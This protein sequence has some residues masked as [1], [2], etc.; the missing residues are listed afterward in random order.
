MK[1]NIE[2]F[3][4]R[5]LSD[6]KLVRQ[7]IRDQGEPDDSLSFPTVVAVDEAGEILGV[8]STD[9]Q[10]NL[11]VA[12]PL[13][14]NKKIRGYRVIVGLVDAYDE[15]MRGMGI[16]SYVHSVDENNKPWLNMIERAYGDEPY[17]KQNGRLFFIKKLDAPQRSVN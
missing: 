13:V 8:L 17:A 4:I 7:F 2:Y 5:E 12:G 14:I 1:G 10:K 6:Y 3:L 9:L 11:V 16:T 15:V